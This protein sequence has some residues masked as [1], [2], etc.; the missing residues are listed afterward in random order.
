V[1]RVESLFGFP[2]SSGTRRGSLGTIVDRIRRGEPV[3][4]FVDRIVSP[5]FTTD[6]AV[7]TRRLI[8]E[9]APAGLYHC[10]N[11]G[12]ATWLE[13]A[14]EAARLLGADFT[15]I[16]LTLET[17]TL[18]A[19]RPRYCALSPARLGSLGIVMPPWRDAMRRYLAGS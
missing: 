19:R 17:V 18:R 1:L 12:A 14:E 2:G 7:A 10:V 3:P 16:P 5:G 11:D 6:V 8:V 15:P 4:V 9:E 13:V